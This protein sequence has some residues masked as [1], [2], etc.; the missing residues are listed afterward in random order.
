[1]MKM[2]VTAL[3]IDDD[4]AH[5]A[6]LFVLVCTISKVTGLMYSELTTVKIDGCTEFRISARARLTRILKFYLCSRALQALPRVCLSLGVG[7]GSIRPLAKLDQHVRPN[8]GSG[9][10]S[11]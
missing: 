5:P 10:I 11:S 1:M 2:A 4:R 3:K 7:A 6:A 9:E 8:L